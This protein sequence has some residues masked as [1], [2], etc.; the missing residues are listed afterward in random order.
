MCGFMQMFSFP[1]GN[2]KAMRD[3][4]KNVTMT[5][6]AGLYNYLFYAMI[7]CKIGSVG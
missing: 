7:L 3:L 6:V 2:S 4:E 5:L 1:G